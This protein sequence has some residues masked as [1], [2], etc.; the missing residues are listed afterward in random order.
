MSPQNRTQVQIKCLEINMNN[1]GD[2]VHVVKNRQGK[3]HE[4]AENGQFT[5]EVW[6]CR[7]KR[8]KSRAVF[9]FLSDSVKQ[10]SFPQMNVT[11]AARLLFPESI[12]HG[13]DLSCC[14]SLYRCRRRLPRV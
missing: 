14:S 5:A 9:F 3:F 4:K 1:I 2:V 12:N 8:L 13:L 7:Q 10:I 11:R 6:H